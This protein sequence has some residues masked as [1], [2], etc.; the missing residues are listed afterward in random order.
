LVFGLYQPSAFR[1]FAI[2]L[3]LIESGKSRIGY[4]G[5]VRRYC[6]SRSSA[7]L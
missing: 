6:P 1:I 2:A 5:P 4:A 7:T 3:G